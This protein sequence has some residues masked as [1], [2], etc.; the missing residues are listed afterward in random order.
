MG[1][2]IVDPEQQLLKMF[3]ILLMNIILKFIMLRQPKT[4][5][6]DIG[7]KIVAN[8]VMVGAI[9]KITEVISKK[10]QLLNQLKVECSCRN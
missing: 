6:D 10:M 7:L 4:A 1:F 3:R 2:L 5:M 8:I 9:T